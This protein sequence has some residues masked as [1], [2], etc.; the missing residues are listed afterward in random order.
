MGILAPTSCLLKGLVSIPVKYSKGQD[1]QHLIPTGPSIAT[2][3]W[4]HPGWAAKRPRG[5]DAGTGICTRVAPCYPDPCSLRTLWQRETGKCLQR[6]VSVRVLAGYMT[7]L[8]YPTAFSL[9]RPHLNRGGEPRQRWPMG[10]V[11]VSAVKRHVE[12]QQSKQAESLLLL[13]RLP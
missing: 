12:K 5:R 8:G 4:G 7:P 3:L 1:A 10:Q 6:P 13:Q 9:A 11:M 2:F